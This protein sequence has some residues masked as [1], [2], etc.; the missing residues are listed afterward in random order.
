MVACPIRR[1][2]EGIIRRLRRFS[3]ILEDEALELQTG[4]L[5]FNTGI[6]LA[7]YQIRTVSTIRP[8]GIAFLFPDFT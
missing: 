1:S 7:G 2:N 4:R 8:C 3:Q 6:P 5:E